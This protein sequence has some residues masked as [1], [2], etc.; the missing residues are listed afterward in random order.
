[1][2]PAI[3][4]SGHTM[5]LG[6]ARALGTMGVPIVVVHY[7]E[8][9]MAHRSRHVTVALRAPHPEKHTEEFI[10]LLLGSAARFAG[11]VIF[12]TSDESLTVAS[13]YK[14]VLEEHF[15]VACPDWAVTRRCI[16]KKLTY[17]LAESSGVAAPRTLVPNSWDEI[18]SYAGTGEFPCLVK[19]CQ[20]HLFYERFQRKMFRVDTPA[21]L[22]DVCERAAEAGLEIMLQELIPGDDSQ[23]VNY[24]AYAWNGVAVAEF[25]AAHVRNAPPWFGSPRVVLS[26]EIPEVLEPGRAIL[27]AIGFS[28]YACT[29]FKKDARSGVYKLMEVNARHNLSTLLAVRCG[30]NFPWLHYRHLVAGELPVASDYRK[31]VYWIDL[32]RDLGYSAIY[33]TRE[34]YTV[35]AYLRP[36]LH[37][38]VFAILDWHDLRPFLRRIA[39]LLRQGFAS[40]CG[41]LLARWRQPW[42]RRSA[43]LNYKSAK[44]ATS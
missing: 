40:A 12:P 16:D 43:N 26:R 14:A 36:Y 2:R 37:P 7:D 35:G 4:L 13:Q 23:V 44:G 18:E 33:L 6:V 9:D 25:T 31:G 34:R 39:H 21:Q 30:T 11:G 41:S 20:S 32:S 27:H 3:I 17:A 24:N 15:I 28:G 22:L 38:H 1:M 29:E 42:Q 8:R 19:P 10:G 5:A